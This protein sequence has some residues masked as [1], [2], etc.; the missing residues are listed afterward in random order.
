MAVENSNIVNLFIPCHMDMF[1]A[2]TAF[3]AKE[4]LERMN[5]ICQYHDEQT[6]CG[7][8][9]FM[10]GDVD[11]AKQ[12][13]TQIVLEQYDEKLPL[14][15]PDSSCAGF[16]RAYYRSLL[17]NTVRPPQ[18]KMFTEHVFELCDFIVNVRKVSCLGNT[19]R[20]R[21][22]YFKSCSARNLYPKNDAPEILLRNTEGLDL[23][24]DEHNQG[25]CGA[26]G[27]FPMVNPQ[28][29]EEMAGEVMKRAY[30]MGAELV[31]STDIHC[32]QMLDAYAVAH[33]VDVDV[34][35]IAD[36]LKGD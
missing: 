13:A 27:R 29:A 3:S 31:T 1:Q 23:L 4:V 17:E 2:S 6:C 22:Y 7:R 34:I 5:I 25:C 32:L 11:S 36:I 9:F 30:S 26:N 24:M 21:V 12:M 14:I 15:I 28:A 20:K 16:M 33:D 8:R 18:L 19:F 10:E 35:H